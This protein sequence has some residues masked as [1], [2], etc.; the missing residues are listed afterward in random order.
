MS[1]LN[2]KVQVNGITLVYN[3]VGKGNPK[4]MMLI[5]GWT[6]FKELF[7]D[8]VPKLV[9][10]G[11]DVVIPDLRGMGIQINH[12]AIILTRFFQRIFTNSQNFLNGKMA[13]S[14]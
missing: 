6:G 3:R 2:L 11:F 14:C 7:S 1:E 8:F 9:D 10:E 13:L 12:K 4:R 5:H